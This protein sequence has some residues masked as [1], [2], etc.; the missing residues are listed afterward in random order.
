MSYPLVSVIIPTYQRGH[1]IER[2]VRSAL[3]QSYSLI[4]VVVSDNASSDQTERVLDGLSEDS[5]LRVVRQDRNIGPV[6]NWRAAVDA[7]NGD[8]IKVNWSDDWMEPQVVGDLVE[9]ILSRERVGFAIANQKVHLN[10]G[11]FETGR[12]RGLVRIEDVAG[13]LLLGLGLPVSP[14]AGL[15]MR[16]DAEWALTEGVG[17]LDP[18]CVDK[19]IGPDLL[20]LYGALRRGLVGVHT[21]MAG[22]HFD[23]GNDS[24]TVREDQGVLRSCYLNGLMALVEETGDR[25]VRAMFHQLLAVRRIRD[26]GRTTVSSQP[27][28]EV[29]LTQVLNPAAFPLTAGQLLL[30]Y[31]K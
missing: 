29:R 20:M 19:A 24:I 28:T 2:A 23:G 31:R 5:R 27:W 25:R 30:A 12:S 1:T 9:A 13:S 18:Q 16:E 14:G 8:L 11:S 3:D 7:A 10:S 22:V 6:A 15:V 26:R 4:E 21:G 17:G